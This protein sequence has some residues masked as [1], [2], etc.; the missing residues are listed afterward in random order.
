MPNLE[1]TQAIAQQDR[2][3]KPAQD[4]SQ[5][6]FHEDMPEP[7][8]V[9]KLVLSVDGVQIPEPRLYSVGIGDDISS[10]PYLLGKCNS[11]G[12]QQF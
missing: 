7:R 6:F 1:G 12:Y 11:V 10:C 3:M 2:I 5:A 4:C 9:H 8:V